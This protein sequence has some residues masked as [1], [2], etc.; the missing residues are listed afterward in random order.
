[1]LRGVPV[2]A[3][4][5]GGIPEAKMGVPYLLP[6]NPIT[7]YETRLDEQ[8]V[9][10]AEVPAQNMAPWREALA[11]LSGDR[12]HYEAVARASRAAALAYAETLTVG[13]F[14]RLLEATPVGQAAEPRRTAAGP[15]L[16]PGKRE[17]L[18]LRLR[19]R[20]P[21]AAW[22]PCIEQVSGPRLFWFPHAGGGTGG[23]A[24]LPGLAPVRLPGREARLAEAPFTRMAPLVS[25]LAGAMAGYLDR[26]FAFF[27]HSMGAVVAFELAREL[28]LRGLPLPRLLVVSG[29]RAPRYRLNHVPGPNPTDEELLAELRRLEG[30]PGE[31]LDDEAALRAILPAL[32][33]DTE[34]YRHY[35]YRREPP[36]P[37][38]IRAYGGAGDPHITAA[39]LEAWAGETTAAF[40]VRRFPGG[41][42][43]LETARA[44]FLRAL[45]EDWEQSA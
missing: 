19:Q 30:T 2:M 10:V 32:R 18:A 21:A 40:A 29:A 38:P 31:L 8:M 4:N 33:A 6:V 34:L 23:A 16:S 37:C 44:E 14:E 41:H 28:R 5:V 45:T 15:E 26:P 43:Y 12:G 17:L 39:H 22:F 11:L 7:R 36:L 20:A 25:A 13:P 24:G 3:A 9:P 35:A 1:M 27:G 42:F